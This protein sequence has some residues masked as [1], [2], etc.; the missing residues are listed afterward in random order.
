MRGRGREKEIQQVMVR[1]IICV[2]T[3]GSLLVGFL[4]LTTTFLSGTVSATASLWFGCLA[5]Q[6]F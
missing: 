1:Y 3:C 2:L 6:L 4:V 5:L